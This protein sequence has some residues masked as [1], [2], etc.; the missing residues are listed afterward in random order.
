MA[1]SWKLSIS[2]DP[3]K[4]SFFL[5]FFHENDSDPLSA[6]LQVLDFIWV[7]KASGS[8]AHWDEGS[9]FVWIPCKNNGA[10]VFYIGKN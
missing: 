8:F 1:M 9:P 4:S 3:K 7:K 10:K 6:V 5:S 2:K